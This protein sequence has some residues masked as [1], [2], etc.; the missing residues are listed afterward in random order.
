[1]Q[2]GRVAALSMG[3]FIND[4][5]P[6]FIAVLLPT[7]RDRLGFSITMAAM[8][9]SIASIFTST[10]QPIFGHLSD[11]YQK[12][13]FVWLGPLITAAFMSCIGLAPS[14]LALVFIVICSGIGTAMFHPLGATYTGKAGGRQSGMAMSLFVTG[15]GAGY[16]V[17][18]LVI[19]GITTTLGL[20]YSPLTIVPGIGVAVILFLILPNLEK[21]EHKTDKKATNGNGH[22][23]AMAFLFIFSIMRSA[24]ISGINTLT[25]IFLENQGTAPM[26]YAGALTLFGIAGSLGPIFS[27][28]LS[29]KFGRKAILVGSMLFSLPFLYL[30]IAIDHTASIY[31]LAATGF[32]I[33]SSIPVVIITAQEL[34]PTRVGIASSL[35]MGLSWGLG[36]LL[37]TPLGS[38]AEHF[39]IKTALYSLVGMGVLATILIAFIPETHKSK[40]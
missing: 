4:M 20:Q 38:L 30:F 14:Y 27:G 6:G 13:T 21:I 31:F 5:Y 35:V 16:Y 3:H 10:I 7:L 39:G 33:F 29:D 1:M 34:F 22:L 15:G 28:G 36:G 25:P 11:K 8:L 12:P 24:M 23:W 37:V 2:K 40:S 9:V 32:A 18:P 19:M 17:G 26:V